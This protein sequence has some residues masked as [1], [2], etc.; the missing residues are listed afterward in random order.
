M[1]YIQFGG[2]G[3]LACHLFDSSVYVHPCMYHFIKSKD[4]HSPSP[5][6]LYI[7]FTERNPYSQGR[8]FQ[9]ERALLW[10]LLI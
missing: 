9:W 8:L 7:V 4:P 10:S 6:A 5:T 1:V 2:I 3:L